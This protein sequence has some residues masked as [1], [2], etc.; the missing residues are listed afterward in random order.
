M[1]LLEGKVAVVTG[2]GR[3]IGQATAVT[4][5]RE[6]ALVLASDIDEEPL[7]E[8]KKLI[9]EAGGKVLCVRADVRS[10]EDCENMMK[11]AAEELGSGAID[12]LA[13]IA[14]ITRDRVIHK[15]S[16]EDWDF[17][18]DVNLRGTFNCI[19]A[20]APYMRDV[21]KKEVAEGKEYHR[22]IINTAS[23]AALRGNPGQINYTAAKGG[24]IGITR[25]VAREWGPFY[26]NCN[27]VAPGLTAT[28]LTQPKKKGDEYG[29]PE[30]LLKRTI[31]SIPFKRAGTPQELANVYLF[32]ASDLSN[33]VT[34]QVINVSGGLVI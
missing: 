25:T 10:R 22:K 21:A 11:K 8:T 1:A 34:G 17:V 20:V 27:C 16:D 30:E 31:E 18:I 5:A 23:T 2:A 15:M 12:I 33:Y 9:E 3:G 19:R 13:N 32:L 7:Q 28:R 4:F 24:I 6:G 26:I 29:I 14:G